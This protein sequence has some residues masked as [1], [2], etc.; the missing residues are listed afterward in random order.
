MGNKSGHFIDGVWVNPADADRLDVLNP[1]TEQVIT[2]ISLGG[3]DEVNAAVAAAR[4]AFEDW[5][6]LPQS[7]RTG[8][9]RKIKDIYARRAAEMAEVL[10]LEMGA[11][12]DF[13]RSAQVAAG[14]WH[15]DGFLD[16]IETHEAETP[17]APGSSEMI[18]QDPVG[19]C[20]LITPWNWPMNQITLKVIPALLVGC[21]VVLK[22]SEATPLSAMLFAEFLEEAGLPPGVFNLVNGDGP[23]VGSPLAA[24]PDVDMMSFTGSTRAGVAVGQACVQTMKRSTLELGGKSPNLIFADCDL[25]AAVSAGVRLCMENTG[26]SC[27]APTRMLVESSVYE[28]AVR[29]AAEVASAIQVAPADPPGDHIG[30]LASAAQYETVQ[31]YI[32]IGLDEGAQLVAGGL[33]K[34]NG[35]E[36]GYF[37]RPTVFADVHNEMA[38]AQEE[39]FG[40]VLVMIP[41][42]D[43][44]DAIAQANASP[45][46][47][48][49]YLSTTDADRAYR[50]SRRL[51]AG[52]IS[53]NQAEFAQG[54]PFGGFKMSGI[55]REGGRFGLE[56]FV[57]I[58]TIAI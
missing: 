27:N 19:V 23:G 15:I 13:A 54:S 35:T 32:R 17:L 25:E 38:I 53:V 11:P 5:R 55:G 30:P 41:F 24:H 56:D 34:P 3:P 7:M 29:I 42:E 57:E 37:A 58:K 44:E 45:F 40:P 31:R 8:Y 47:L 39:I 28:R 20:G 22:P 10:S 2:A 36:V 21:T 50:V 1:S 46:G 9:V 48:A 12:I 18:V 6:A 16:A 33:G 26:Q 14:A 51:Q 43:E 52:M 4:R 49:A